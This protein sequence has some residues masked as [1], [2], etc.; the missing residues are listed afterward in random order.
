MANY[1][2]AEDLILDKAIPRP[3]GSDLS[4]YVTQASAAMDNTL[5]RRYAT[6]I[7]VDQT[8]P[9]FDRDLELLRSICAH[10]A[11]GYFVLAITSSREMAQIHDYGRWLIEQ[12]QQWLEHLVTGEIDLITV[13]PLPEQQDLPMDGAVLSSSP[14]PYS[15]TDAYYHNF[16]PY[17]FTDGRREPAK[18]WP[19]REGQI[20]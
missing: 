20:P 13:Q 2:T 11:T 15:L 3:A 17:G 6:P 19:L 12:A 5:R 16:E 14:H 7:E 8:R 9:G 4:A 10:L 18:N 1:C